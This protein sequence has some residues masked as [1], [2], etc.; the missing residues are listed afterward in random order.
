[1]N[2]INKAKISTCV[3][4]FLCLTPSLILTSCSKDEQVFEQP[5]SQRVDEA[6][7][8][9]RKKLASSEHGWIMEYYPHSKQAYGG[10]VIGFKFDDKGNVLIASEHLQKA[11]QD[12]VATRSVYD[13]NRDRSI[14][15]NFST[16]NQHIHD[17]ADPGLSIGAGSGKGLEGDFEFLVMESDSDDLIIL[18][19]KKTKNVIKMYRA[20]EPFKDYLRSVVAVRDEMYTAQGLNKEHME[21][22]TGTFGGKKADLIPSET[23]DAYYTLKFL[24]DADNALQGKKLPYAVRP[25]GIRFYEPISGIATLTWNAGDKTFTSDKGDKLVARPDAVYPEYAKYLGEYSFEYNGGKNKFDATFSEGA[26]NEYIIT[27]KNTPLVLKGLYDAEHH[28]FELRTQPIYD[29]EAQLAVW[30]APDGTNLS[31]GGTSGMYSKLVEGSNPATYEMVDNGAWG[32]F[33]AK[34]FVVWKVGSGLLEKGG[35]NPRIV[36]PKF[37]RKN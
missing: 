37:I 23:G 13:L 25:E 29:G 32:A 14:T 34:S 31:W 15:L 33:V 10:Y 22:L 4:G 18:K 16:Y 12:I 35:V 24:D 17:Y 28:R 2:I 3:L 19:G 8:A 20:K 6:T 36:Q 27:I 11:G 21:A 26:R 9:F 5:A 1:M 7:N 30:A